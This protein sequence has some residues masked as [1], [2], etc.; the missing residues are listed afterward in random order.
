MN[1]LYLF[2]G[3][4]NRE[5]GISEILYEHSSLRKNQYLYAI[6]KGVSDKRDK[7]QKGYKS[8]RASKRGIIRWII[9]R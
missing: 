4:W 6:I 2:L 7:V 3:V 1:L 8:C 5:T 9:S